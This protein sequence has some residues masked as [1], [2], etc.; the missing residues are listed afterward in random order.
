MTTAPLVRSGQSD[1]VDLGEVMGSGLVTRAHLVRVL[2]RPAAETAIRTELVRVG[3]GRYAL[4]QVAEASR[5]AHGLS[6]L[7]CLTS[8]ALHHGWEVLRVPERPH[9]LVPRKRKV[10][11]QQQAGV[12]LHRRDVEAGEVNGYATSQELTLMMCLQRLSFPEALAVAD[13]ALRSGVAPSTLRRVALVAQGP[14]APQAR[15]VATCANGDAANPFES[16][17][18]AAALDVEGLTLVPQVWVTTSSGRIR[19]DLVDQDLQIVAEADSFAWH[20]DR[21][22]LARDCRRYNSLVAEGYLVLRFTWEDVMFHP[23]SVTETL[24]SAVETR[25]G[26]CFT[27]LPQAQ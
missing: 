22:A 24:R 21:A 1:G 27:C 13:S 16:G 4:P 8:A 23:D 26:T 5:A 12:V 14:G 25:T 11:P 9:V 19:P 10:A 2:G 15:R 7:L 20:G 3:R 18:R 6:G 17:L